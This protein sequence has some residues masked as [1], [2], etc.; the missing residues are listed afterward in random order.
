ME[1]EKKKQEITMLDDIIFEDSSVSSIEKIDL[2]VEDHGLFEQFTCIDVSN[3]GRHQI[4]EE[5]KK[6]DPLLL[7]ELF[8]NSISS[9]IENQNDFLR[10]VL[11]FLAENEN[12]DFPKKIQII[13]IL[14]LYSGTKDSPGSR[15]ENPE[16]IKKTFDYLINIL[17][18]V[19]IY[20]IDLQKKFN[21]STTLLFDTIKQLFKKQHT[22]DAIKNDDKNITEIIFTTIQNIYKSQFINEDFKYKLFDSIKKD[23]Q[24]LLD[25]KIKIA[26][27]IVC[28]YFKNY[29]YNLFTCQYLLHNNMIERPHL[30]FL[31]NIANGSSDELC[32]ADIADFFLSI[33]E[34]NSTAFEKHRV[35]LEEFRSLALNL[36]NKIKWNAG[37]VNKNIYNN[38]QNIHSINIDKSVKP[39]FEK[40]ITIDFDSH[41]PSNTDDENIHKTITEIIET[42]KNVIENNKMN[43]SIEKIERTIQ[44]FILDN[45]VYTE[46]FLS[47]LHLL[48]RCYFYIM[49][50]NGGNEELQKRFVEEMAEMA[51]TCSTGHLVRLANI[52]SGFDTSM[53]MDVEEELKACIFHRLTNIINSKPESVKE[54]IY[55]DIQSEDFMKSLSHDLVVLFNELEKEY[56][57]SKIMNIHNLQESFRKYVTQFQT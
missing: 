16:H 32:I 35:L 34:G 26:K 44:R 12:I 29:K 46:K 40:L 52:F 2:H 53:F 7:N 25:I 37:T 22:V 10:S 21:V 9:F 39:F 51:D 30:E 28:F 19:S 57:D 15:R 55:E 38:K 18:E 49:I 48:F 3:N 42:C 54:K 43:V 23:Q 17:Y 36:F 20:N 11:Y 33:S 31:Y 41:I 1:T 6:R 8:I 4:I 50:T 5:L 45:N 24:I 56:V 47:L 27:L 13:E 14:Y